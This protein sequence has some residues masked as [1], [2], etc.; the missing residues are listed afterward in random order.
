MSELENSENFDIIQYCNKLYHS[1]SW[2]SMIE[3]IRSQR[4]MVN[5]PSNFKETVYQNRVIKIKYLEHNKLWKHKWARQ[6][7]GIVM[8]LDDDDN[9]VPL[10]YQLQR[11]A[12]VLTQT[13][14]LNG[15]DET[16]DTSNLPNKITMLDDD[17]QDVINKLLNLYPI[18]GTLS[19]K[20]D[21]SLLGITYYFGKYKD[22]V[23]NFVKTTGDEFA[24][25]FYEM[26]KMYG[27]SCVAS[28]QNTFFLGNDMQSYNVSAILGNEYGDGIL[29]TI[30]NDE[31]DYK[32]AF[33]KHGHQWLAKI[34]KLVDYV[35][36]K[37]S[38]FI[39]ITLNFESICKDRMGIWDSFSHTELAISYPF[40]ATKFLGIS[41]CG[42]NYI[43]FI[44]HFDIDIVK[45]LNLTEPLYW[46]ISDSV[47]VNNILKNLESVIS[48]KIT[49]NEFLNIHKPSNTVTKLN[50][51]LD[52]EGFVFFTPIK[53][54]SEEN[55]IN[56]NYNK[57]K[58]LAYYKAHK[59]KFDNVGYL[60]KIAK[61]CGHIFPLATKVN[62]F[63]N[64]TFEK[65]YTV[66]KQIVGE[67]FKPTDS[68]ILFQGLPEKASM[69]FVKQ[70]KETQ[71][72]I[73]INGSNCFETVAFNI[74]AEQFADLKMP[75]NME[76][77]EEIKKVI[78]TIVM[79]LKLWK[80]ESEDQ[81]GEIISNYTKTIENN[82]KLQELLFYCINS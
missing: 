67:I 54:N 8:Y 12:E 53:S 44:P 51:V 79:E 77:T 47:Q 69:S 46:K 1:T 19:F 43:K 81:L 72:K 63:F 23:D 80:V 29:Q 58:T 13:H 33:L 11:G 16:D 64:G 57:I 40:S 35:I 30:A 7:R 70:S 45:D 71:V 37:Y 18:D 55:H 22:V 74:F 78:K 34:S 6:C 32:L 27:H 49:Q 17:Q 15:I 5:C 9:I 2:E 59:F 73:L 14:V 68:N 4:F 56:Y 60:I 41:I 42:T 50:S 76:K 10:K 75:D 65:L 31:S 26:G 82:I 25:L 66:S 36:Q 52:F 24:K 39:T 3:T 62:N 61:T 28:S 21:G 38:N 48:Q 20:S